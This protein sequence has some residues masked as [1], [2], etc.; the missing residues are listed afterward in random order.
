M[1]KIVVFWR[2]CQLYWKQKRRFF[3]CQQCI[4]FLVLCGSFIDDFNLLVNELST[5]HRMLIVGAFNLDQMLPEHIVKVD[6]LIQNFNL[7]QRLQHSTHIYGGILDLVLDTSSSN[8][9]ST[10]SFLPSPYSDHFVFLLLLFF[11][12]LMDYIYTEFTI[13]IT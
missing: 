5:Q 13:L 8:S 12:N 9:S 11:S 6:T 10:V 7:S 4:V 1:T 2:Y 3:Y